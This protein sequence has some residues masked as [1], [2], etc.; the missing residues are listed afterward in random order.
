[1][2]SYNR[3]VLVGNLTRDPQLRTLPS[4]MSVVEI[5]LA[6]NHRYKTQSG[7]Q[8]EEV[9]FVDCTAFGKTGEIINQYMTKGK[10]ILV[11]GR[12]KLDSW[13][14]KQGGG[15]R[16]KHTVVIDNF[17]FLGGR[18]DDGSG[19]GGG[20]GR[21][22][23]AG[24]GGGYGNRGGYTMDDDNGGGGDGGNGGGAPPARRAPARP[25][26]A[27]Q[28]PAEEAPFDEGEQHFEDDDIPF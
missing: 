20:G 11:E 19:G 10:P 13:D 12:L 23:S 14:D 3:V 2:P 15:K 26:R 27:P 22:R 1:M 5:G 21:A 18:D 17:Q 16:S 7:E 28:K 25:A 6:I 24:G 9:C 4:Q 8:R